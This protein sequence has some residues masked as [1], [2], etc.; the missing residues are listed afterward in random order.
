L[1][2]EQRLRLSSLAKLLVPYRAGTT[3][4][5]GVTVT[6]EVLRATSDL[7]RLHGATPLL[8]VLQF[9]HEE[10]PEQM[11]RRRILDDASIP[12]V[13]VE[14]DSSW[15]LPWDRHPN[16]RAAHAIATAIANELRRRLTV[17]RQ[18]PREQK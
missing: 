5:R 1:P 15:R 7:A 9:G 2:A 17:A 8:V 13:L 16:S 14:M 3:V 11:W 4:D 12:Y 18:V 6:R 10:Q